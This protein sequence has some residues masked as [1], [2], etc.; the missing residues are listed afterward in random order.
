MAL[1]TKSASMTKNND[2]IRVLVTDNTA[3]GAELLARSLNRDRRFHVLEPVIGPDEITRAVREHQPDVVILTHL[4]EDSPARFRTARELRASY[5]NIRLVVILDSSHRHL[6]V[7]AFRAG[8]K[9]ILS[10]DGSIKL[11]AKCLECVHQGQIWATCAEL[12]FLIDALVESPPIRLANSK[13]ASLLSPQEQA[14]VHWMT[15]GLSNREIAAQLRLSEHTVKN[16]IF[17]I[18]DKL[19]VSKRVEVI[20]YALSKRDEGRESSPA[21]DE[22]MSAE[23]RMMFQWSRG[24]AEQGSAMAGFMLGQM[25]RDGKGVRPDYVSA[26]AWFQV[27]KLSSEDLRE[28][29]TLACERLSKKMTP[30]EIS[31]ALTRVVETLEKSR[32]SQEP[33]K[34]GHFL[35]APND[36]ETSGLRKA[37]GVLAKAD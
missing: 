8:A 25:Y 10:R 1:T 28:V 35:N 24:L 4:H 33:T 20:L 6:V 9:G 32:K 13:G 17:R 11:L 16:Y 23:D 14:V 19:G 30:D 29:S 22:D 2:T 37:G 36:A 27:T 7:E 18:F 31:M 21:K 15:E 3:M 34:P 12:Q 5:P 26:F